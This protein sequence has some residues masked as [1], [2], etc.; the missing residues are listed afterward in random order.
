MP[1]EFRNS[2]EPLLPNLTFKVRRATGPATGGGI[3]P[4]PRHAD[5]PKAIKRRITQLKQK[6]RDFFYNRLRDYA[7]IE[8]EELDLFRAILDA[9]IEVLRDRLRRLF[10][11]KPKQETLFS[12]GPQQEEL[13]L[14]KAIE[15]QRQQLEAEIAE[16][17][18]QKRHLK[19]ERP[20]IWS[21]ESAEIFSTGV[22]VRHHHPATR[23]MYDRRKLPT[24]TA[25]YP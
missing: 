15:E 18:A 19:D 11:P 6:K 22:R 3:F 20:F 23:P 8:K 16:L 12:I 14:D 24:P 17:Q 7:L 5:L 2:F 1:D 21:I 10:A 25:N 9:E 4:G 13:D